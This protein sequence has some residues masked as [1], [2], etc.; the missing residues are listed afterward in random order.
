[1]SGL[2]LEVF[3]Q[4]N[5]WAILVSGLLAFTIGGIW[6]SPALFEGSWMAANGYSQDQIQANMSSLVPFG[7]IGA[8]MVYTLMATVFAYLSYALG[9]DSVASCI[10]TGLL[11]WAGFVASSGFMVMLFSPNTFSGWLIDAGFQLT[12][13]VAVGFVLG[14]WR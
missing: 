6:Y 3:S 14:A 2:S 10:L 5:Y 9:A 7:F 11:I 8:I 13:L 12:S 4:L 1:M